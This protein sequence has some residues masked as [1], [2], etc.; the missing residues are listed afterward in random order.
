MFILPNSISNIFIV[1]SFRFSFFQLICILIF[2]YRHIFPFPIIRNRQSCW[3]RMIALGVCAWLRSIQP[4]GPPTLH[5]AH[6]RAA[7]A[8]PGGAAAASRATTVGPSGRGRRREPRRRWRPG[9][10]GG[11][12]RDKVGA[13]E[14]CRHG[15]R[16]RTHAGGTGPWDAL[17]RH[18]AWAPL[19]AGTNNI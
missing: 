5:A 7:A 9:V 18:L 15:A 12:R 1:S 4:R 10:G 19:A 17:P 6:V 16:A 3:S 2:L 11:R 14:D 8:E 13:P